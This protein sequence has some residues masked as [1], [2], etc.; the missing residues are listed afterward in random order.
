MELFDFGPFPTLLTERLVLR[1]LTPADPACILV[2]WGD[3]EVQHYN[4]PLL[5][6]L[7]EAQ[8][9]IAELRAAYAARS[10]I[11]WAVTLRERLGVLGVVDFHEWDRHHRRA[12]IG[13][14]LARSSW[15]Q[16]IASEAVR[17]VIRF[18]F[19]RMHLHRIEA[20]TI[21]DNLRSVRLLEQFGFRREGIRREYSLEDDGAFH[22]S[23]IYG[24]LEQEAAAVP[25][26]YSERTAKA[27]KM[28]NEQQT[29]ASKDTPD[30]G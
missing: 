24:L 8:A 10:Q 5:A 4:G 14:S 28:L 12:E 7:D 27:A 3:P 9:V 6:N 17:A 29:R 2:L 30:L 26:T 23:A 18:G 11:A 20:L 13:Y 1:E 16:G 22:D 21:A 15:G 25:Y 19:A